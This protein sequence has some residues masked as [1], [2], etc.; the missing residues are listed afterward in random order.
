VLQGSSHGT[1]EPNVITCVLRDSGDSE[2]RHNNQWQPPSHPYWMF[3]NAVRIH[4]LA[5][6]SGVIDS[7][8]TV[9]TVI[10][11]LL[12]FREPVTFRQCCGLTLLLVGLYLVH[13][14]KGGIHESLRRANG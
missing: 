5:V 14:K 11:A 13:Q 12:L 2:A 7:L 8:L 9:L 4:G 6:A 1:I 3:R 10:L